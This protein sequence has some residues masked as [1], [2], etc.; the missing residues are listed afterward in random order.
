MERSVDA[1]GLPL[2]TLIGIAY[3]LGILN[4]APEFFKVDESSGC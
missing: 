3:A 2:L 1:H 4:G